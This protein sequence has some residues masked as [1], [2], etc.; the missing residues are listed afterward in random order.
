MF[1]FWKDQ[2]FSKL[3]TFQLSRDQTDWEVSRNKQN[4]EKTL[5]TKRKVIILTMLQS[6]QYLWLSDD[7]ADL[8]EPKNDKIN[9]FDVLEVCLQFTICSL[10]SEIVYGSLK[11]VGSQRT[12]KNHKSILKMTPKIFRILINT[13]VYLLGTDFKNNIVLSPKRTK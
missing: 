7:K 2:Y 9:T 11:V 8:Q 13:C 6:F 3:V 12:Q 4:I 5:Y 1:S 10:I